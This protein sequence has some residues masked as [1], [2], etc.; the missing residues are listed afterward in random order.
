MLNLG[1]AGDEAGATCFALKGNYRWGVWGLGLLRFLG[2]RVYKGL[3]FRVHRFFFLGPFSSLAL[4]S[5]VHRGLGFRVFKGTTG[6]EFRYL[7]F[8]RVNGLGFI[9]V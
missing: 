6:G 2:F 1:N 7:G 4:Q 5:P 8:I 3:G 9:R